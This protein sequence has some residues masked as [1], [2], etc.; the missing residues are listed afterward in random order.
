[1]ACASEEVEVERVGL[2]SFVDREE[3][4]EELFLFELERG[5]GGC[6]RKTVADF[7][8]VMLKMLGICF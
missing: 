8:V 4:A 5:G 3:V 6:Y 1:M 2:H 7:C